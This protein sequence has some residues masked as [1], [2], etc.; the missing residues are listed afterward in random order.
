MKVNV[1]SEDIFVYTA[2]VVDIIQLGHSYGFTFDVDK[3]GL[4]ITYPLY[5]SDQAVTVNSMEEF[6]EVCKDISRYKK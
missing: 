1:R 3:D 2:F 5:S 4:K 6:A